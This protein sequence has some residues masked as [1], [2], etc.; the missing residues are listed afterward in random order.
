MHLPYFKIVACDGGCVD[1]LV[2]STQSRRQ[3]PVKLTEPL[4][5]ILYITED[6][7]HIIELHKA[8]HVK[9]LLPMNSMLSL[10]IN[11][12]ISLR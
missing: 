5:A 11:T 8:L 4:T 12:A 7:Q 9:E 6:K 10:Y 1:G 3:C 2:L